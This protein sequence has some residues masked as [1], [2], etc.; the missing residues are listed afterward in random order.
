PEARDDL[1]L[2]HRVERAPPPVDHQR[3][4]RERL[5]APTELALGAPDALRDRPDLAGSLGEDRDDPIGLTELDPRQDDALFLVERHPRMV[6]P[7]QART[8]RS[9]LA[10]P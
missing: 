7:A 10:I 8:A 2:G 6:P 3:D 4:V 1:G 5:Q 9:G